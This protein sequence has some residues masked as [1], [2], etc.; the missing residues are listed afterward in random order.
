[1]NFLFTINE[2]YVK[3]IKVLMYSI[4][5]N[6]PEF[7]RFFFLHRDIGEKSRAEINEWA[8]IKCGGKA[9]FIDFPYDNIINDFPVSGGW[10]HEIYYRLFAPYLLQDIEEIVYLDGDTIVNG[11]LVELKKIRELAVSNYNESFVIAA[12]PNDIQEEHKIRLGLSNENTYINSGVMIINLRKWRETY[13]LEEMCNKLVQMKAELKF[14]DQDFI[15]VVWR[16][17]IHLL[18]KTYNYMVNLAERDK[19]YFKIKNPLICHYVLAKPWVD[20]FEYKTDYFYLKYLYKSGEYIEAIRL[21]LN[22][23]LLRFKVKTKNMIQGIKGYI[24]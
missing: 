8:K 7:N 14:P 23:G 10:S 6:N 17:E 1:M 19:A 20:Y 21:Y 18:G 3:Q 11:N 24:E 2:K 12:V 4:Y 16:N 15:N 22:H 5:S 9:I 13:S